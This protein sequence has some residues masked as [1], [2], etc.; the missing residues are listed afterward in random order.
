M[1][2]RIAESADV[3]ATA[4]IGA[5]SSIWHLAQIRE[6]ARVGLSCVV[7]RGV[8]I[9][10]GIIIGDMTKIQNHA[11]I[12]EPSELGDGVFVG[13][14]VVLTNDVF[15]RA[16]NPDFTPKGPSDWELAGVTINEGASLGAQSVCVA[17]VVIGRWAMVAAGSVV[18]K[19]VPDF[20]LV[21]GSPA[22]QKGWVGR[23][24]RRLDRIDSETWRCPATGARFVKTV[25]N[26]LLTEE[27][28]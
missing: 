5:G 22:V 14:G 19:D 6:N 25:D 23:A 11:L 24:G 21:A 10:P 15:P 26:A 9:G 16:V 17:P 1:S 4:Q 3:D 28:E 18:L 13:P 2:T 20:A 8:Y 27:D 12:Y 7:G